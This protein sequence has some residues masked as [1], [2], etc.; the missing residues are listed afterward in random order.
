LKETKIVG[1]NGQVFIPHFMREKMGISETNKVFM[2]C[3]EDYVVVKKQNSPEQKVFMKDIIIDL[4]LS[5]PIS[6]QFDMA[7]TINFLL[8]DYADNLM[9]GGQMDNENESKNKNK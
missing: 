5:L 4:I 9:K 8:A 2:F 7:A 3:S 1:K 6:R